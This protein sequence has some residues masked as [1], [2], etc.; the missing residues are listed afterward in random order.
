[1]TWA[2][3]LNQD[4]EAVLKIDP[5]CQTAKVELSAVHRMIKSAVSVGEDLED[6]DEFPSIDHPAMEL[7]DSD[8]LSGTSGE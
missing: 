4:F 3:G 8:S 6:A 1:M 2:D 7:D 5:Q